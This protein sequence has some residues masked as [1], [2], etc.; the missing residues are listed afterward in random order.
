MSG[1]PPG[2][3]GAVGF[4]LGHLVSDWG[5][6]GSFYFLKEDLRRMSKGSLSPE[7][8]S[9]GNTPFPPATFSSILKM[10]GDPSWGLWFFPSVPLLNAA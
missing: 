8:G 3:S 5:I 9:L 4:T 7:S 10:H 6:Q 1:P 2:G